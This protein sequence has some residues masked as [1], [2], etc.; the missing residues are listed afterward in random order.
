MSACNCSIG[1]WVEVDTVNMTISVPAERM[2]EIKEL[3]AEWVDKKHCSKVELQSVIGKLQFITKCVRQ[4]RVFLNR[5]LQTLKAMTANSNK[6]F[7]LMDSFKKDIKWWS[8][9]VEEYNGSIFH[10]SHR[11]E[12]PRFQFLDR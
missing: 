11:V 3:L 7:R 12:R 9:F 8:M 5:I 10:T 4:S 2:E 6:R 1:A